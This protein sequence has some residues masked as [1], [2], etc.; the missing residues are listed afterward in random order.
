MDYSDTT[1]IIPTLNEERNIAELLEDLIS[2][3]N[4]ITIIV[5]DDG[6]K[7]R[8]QGIV[9][10]YHKKNKKIILLDRSEK[11]I[12]G[13]TVSVID[14][15]KKVKTRFIV[16]M[17]GD[18]QHP[19]EKVKEIIKK[20]RFGSDIV[21]GVRKKVYFG[22]LFRL[23]M[24]KIAVILGQLRLLLQGIKCND[25]VSGFFGV[26][27]KLFQEKIK[28]YENRFEKEGY[29]VL[30]DLLKLMNN[31]AKICEISYIFG[32]RKRGQSKINRKHVFIYLRSLFK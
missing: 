4:G 3:Y 28:K 12:H 8:T 10:L 11:N 9:R 17:D 27:T 24:S 2:Y 5:S 16:V 20:L 7:D 19:P 21:I 14:A 18:M 32:N 23:C 29:K 1:V 13:L 6:S 22:S 26:R 30:F 15:A 25:V 31:R